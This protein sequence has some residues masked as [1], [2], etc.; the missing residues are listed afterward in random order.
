MLYVTV[1]VT[2]P[3]LS[4]KKKVGDKEG[5]ELDNLQSC[6]FKIVSKIKHPDYVST[7]IYIFGQTFG[8]TSDFSN[9][10]FYFFKFYSRTLGYPFGSA[11]QT[12]QSRGAEEYGSKI[13]M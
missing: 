2:Y 13:A 3:L 8:S 9:R 5:V 10:P 1:Q 6:N 4:L 7:R 12:R 11:V